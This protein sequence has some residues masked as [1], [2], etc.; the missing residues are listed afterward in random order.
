[1]ASFLVARVRIMCCL[2]QIALNGTYV[3]TQDACLGACL[4]YELLVL[5]IIGL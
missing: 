3:L 2:T 4:T 5:I 1:M